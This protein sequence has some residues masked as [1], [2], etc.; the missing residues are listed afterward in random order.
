VSTDYI[1]AD[2]RWRVRAIV[3]N[4]REWLRVEHDSPFVNGKLAVH[5]DGKHRYGPVRTGR[6]WWLVN[7]VSSIAQVEEYVPLQS[8]TQANP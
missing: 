4:G 1:S 3:L 6:S 8:L 2:A 7:D 5:W